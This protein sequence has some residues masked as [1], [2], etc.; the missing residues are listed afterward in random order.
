MSAELFAALVMVFGG[1]VLSGLAG[2]GFA[3][4]VVPPLLLLYEPPTVT[5]VAISLTLVTGWIVLLETWRQVQ[6]R[7]VLGLVPGAVI[8]LGI[9]VVLIRSLDGDAIKL[10]ASLV[11]LL[12]SVSLFRGWR[13]AGVHSRWAPPLAGL[14]SGALNTSTGMASPPV[15]LLMASRNYGVHEFRASIIAYFYFVDLL[16]MA[17]L[18]Q[19]GIVG[20]DEMMVVATLLAPAVA[21]TFLGRWS[22]RRF[23]VGGFRRL[24]LMLLLITGLVGIVSAVRGL[25]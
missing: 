9:G 12:F 15:A 16:G 19:Q 4:V 11:V 22:V 2:F 8:G 1:G 10:L 3:L 24:T 7:T 5:A 13:F 20:R 18:I 6:G 23:S 21:G 17:L 25:W 14:F